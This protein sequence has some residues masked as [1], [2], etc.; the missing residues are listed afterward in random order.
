M[1]CLTL[2]NSN[3]SSSGVRWGHNSL[4]PGEYD[5]SSIAS[6]ASLYRLVSLVKCLLQAVEKS[7]NITLL[8]LWRLPEQGQARLLLAT[9]S[10]Y[11]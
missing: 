10:T 4:M 11:L 2:I 3:R 1:P 5:M 6:R 7:S 8:L 9:R